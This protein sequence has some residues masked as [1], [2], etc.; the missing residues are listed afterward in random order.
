MQR[1]GQ[2]YGDD[3]FA[4]CCKEL[5]KALDTREAELARLSAD[6]LATGLNKQSDALGE[7]TFAALGEV[8]AYPVRTVADL[9]LKLETIR[10]VDD[11]PID[12]D[13]LL[14]DLNR[15]AGRA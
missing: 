6:W 4:T 7:Q 14:A 15:I 10:E 9:T 12:V 3:D 1:D 13:D 8:Y 5:E 11:D 2:T